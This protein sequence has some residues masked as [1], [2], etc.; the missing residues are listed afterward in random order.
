[1]NPAPLASRV[2]TFIVN[3]VDMSEY[4]GSYGAVNL[5]VRI[6]PIG[7]RILPEINGCSRQFDGLF[8]C[9]LTDELD[10]DCR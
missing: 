7:N 2:V 1:M 9:T 5:N 8:T 4:T 3:S 6:Q 10:D